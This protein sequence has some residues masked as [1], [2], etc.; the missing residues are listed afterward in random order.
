MAHNTQDWQISCKKITER[1]KRL[2]KL[3]Q[4]IDCTFLVGNEP[5]QIVIKGHKLI[6]AMASPVFEAMF[7]GGMPEINDPILIL[8]VQP[9]AFKALLEYVYSDEVHINS[10][11]KACEL[12]YAAKKY[13]LPHLVQECTNYMWSDLNPKN[14]CRAYEF[15]KLFEEPILMERCLQIICTQT[16]EVLAESSFE[17]IELAT[18]IKIFEQDNLNIDSEMELFD[19]AVRYATSQMFT[20]QNVMLLQRPC[21]V[22]VQP[23][24]SPL[25][26]SDSTASVSEA[27]EKAGLQKEMVE[28]SDVPTT[29]S[30]ITKTSISDDADEEQQSTSTIFSMRNA[31]QK[32]RFLTLSPQEFAEGPAQSNLLSQ[33]EAFSILMNISSPRS[34]F[35]MPEGFTSSTRR[36]NK[37]PVVKWPPDCHML[38]EVGHRPDSSNSKR[39]L[40]DT[41]QQIAVFSIETTNRDANKYYCQ[42]SI[43]HGTD[44]LNTCDLE[45]SVTFTV[46]KNICVIGVQIPT[47]VL[48]ED[49]SL[50][51]SAVTYSELL[52]AHLLDA[53]GSRLTYTHYTSRVPY[54][55]LVDII[56]NRPFYI[57]RNKVY[58]VAVVFNKLGWYPMGDSRSERV[59][60]DNVCFSF[61]VGPTSDS[62]RDGLIRSIIYTY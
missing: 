16:V 34:D 2:L 55:S 23:A 30:E 9:E 60:Y 43:V 29:S 59:V 54:S 32:I 49:P 21:R 19:A 25:Q 14:A 38:Q 40:S 20:V 37:V 44:C 15:A 41:L 17:D 18:M 4:W 39:H 50:V 12:C 31:I 36:R 53:D 6:L 13:M 10:F 7:F 22:S 62:V 28:S 57:Q 33:Q 56:F 24:M 47:Q 42:R 5:N 48:G 46:D 27:P 1:G 51:P 58:K 61:G 35:S 26:S 11:D 45:C 3:G 52:Y 8:D